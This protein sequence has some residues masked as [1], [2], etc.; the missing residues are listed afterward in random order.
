MYTKNIRKTNRN[1][2]GEYC[3]QKYKNVDAKEI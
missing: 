3:T 1:R 2:S